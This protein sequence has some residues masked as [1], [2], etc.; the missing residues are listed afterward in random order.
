MDHISGKAFTISFLNYVNLFRMLKTNVGIKLLQFIIQKCN[1]KIKY[2]QTNVYN[3]EVF[4]RN[5][6][7]KHID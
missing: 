1:I 2:T 7:I 4:I 5:G 3:I 6:S